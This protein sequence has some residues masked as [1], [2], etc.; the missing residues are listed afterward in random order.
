[1]WWLAKYGYVLDILEPHNPNFD[2]NLGKAQGLAEY[3]RKYGKDLGRVALIREIDGRLRYL[4]LADS[5]V[6]H[7]VL[8]AKTQGELNNIFDKRIFYHI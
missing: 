2:D 1:M 7:E 3:A 4:N 6:M 8:N 5:K